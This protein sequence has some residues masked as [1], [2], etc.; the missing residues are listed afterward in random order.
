M[1]LF[2]LFLLLLFY[3]DIEPPGLLTV[4]VKLVLPGRVIVFRLCY[5]F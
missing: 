2:L 1:L 3:G 4:T 5:Y